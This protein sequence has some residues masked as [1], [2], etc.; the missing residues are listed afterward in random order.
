M[1]VPSQYSIAPIQ[2]NQEYFLLHANDP[3]S[4]LY[5]LRNNTQHFLGIV[6]LFRDQHDSGL[7]VYQP[8]VYTPS[9]IK[10][11]HI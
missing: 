4:S 10:D 1:I 9:A 11:K 3:V 6:M 7:L 2:R 5:R 8:N